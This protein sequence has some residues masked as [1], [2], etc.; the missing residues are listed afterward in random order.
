MNLTNQ[1]SLSNF[2]QK[3]SFCLGVL[4]ILVFVLFFPVYWWGMPNGYD[5]PFHYQAAQA[6]FN[7]FQ[8]GNFLPA[9]SNVANLG[10]G[11]TTIRYYPPLAQYSLALFQLATEDW[12]TSLWLS[13]QLWMLLA[14]F[15]AYFF[16]KEWLSPLN[17]FYVAALYAIA[18][19][20]LTQAYQ[21]FLY[22]EFAAA[23]VLPFCF[24]YLTRVCRNGTAKD[25][26]GL[27]VSL[28]FLILC[29]LPALIVFTVCLGFYAIL[30]LDW[31]NFR[32]V[33]PKLGLSGTGALAAT[34]F[35]W[36]RLISELDFYNHLS[37]KNF[38]KGLNFAENFFPYYLR[39]FDLYYLKLLWLRDTVSFLTLLLLLPLLGYV[40]WNFKSILPAKRKL[41]LVF[42]LT[43]IFSFYM[44]SNLSF[45]IWSNVSFLQ[46]VQFPF[47]FLTVAGLF[48][49]LGFVIAFS[50]LQFSSNAAKTI[51]KYIVLI[52]LFG[53]SLFNITQLILPS[54]TLPREIFEEKLQ[55]IDAKPSIEASWTIWSKE[56]AF[57]QKEKVIVESR[58]VNINIWKDEIREFGVESGAETKARIATFYFPYWQAT[59]NGEKAV[60]ELNADGTM[61][62]PIPADSAKI[63]LIFIEPFSL[64]IAKIVS[65]LSWFGFFIFGIWSLNKKL[66]I[67]N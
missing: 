42:V 11:D 27:S 37:P 38:T 53:V 57:E 23:G 45:L 66:A 16:A 56:T 55:E 58:N 48:G 9:W 41:Y 47:R 28:A 29:N 5:L 52:F 40:V 24:L 61:S 51:N 12:L 32:H 17:S 3:D 39:E 18:P 64:K 14:V 10:F 33:I 46:K 2:F 54:E 59:V 22:A 30:M 65:L 15:G 4:S 6:Y 34:S 8:A 31:K 36:V 1:K 62:I 26:L 13:L 67:N 20:H 25:V 19:Y 7:S 63:S 44:S 49:V 60:V 43:G 35:Y 50:H 21:Y